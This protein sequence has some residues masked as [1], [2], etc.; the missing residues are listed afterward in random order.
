VFLLAVCIGIARLAGALQRQ[1][2]HWEAVVYVERQQRNSCAEGVPSH[3]A[4][5]AL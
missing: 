1:P 2:L 4:G 5:F 3:W